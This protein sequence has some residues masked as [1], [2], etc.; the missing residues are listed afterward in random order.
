MASVVI[1]SYSMLQSAIE[2]TNSPT[3][4][5]TVDLQHGRIGERQSKGMRETVAYVNG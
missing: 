4:G 3:E 2:Q 1:E 5:E